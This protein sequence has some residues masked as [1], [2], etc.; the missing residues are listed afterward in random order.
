[1]RSRRL[2]RALSL[3]RC[4]PAPLRGWGCTHE[5]QLCLSPVGHRGDCGRCRQYP[6]RDVQVTPGKRDYENNYVVVTRYKD[7]DCRAC[8]QVLK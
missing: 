4:P 5:A 7:T 2:A 1:M 6:Q 3:P 8:L